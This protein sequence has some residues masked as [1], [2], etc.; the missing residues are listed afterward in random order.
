MESKNKLTLFGA[1]RQKRYSENNQEKIKLNTLKRSL[2]TYSNTVNVP[3]YGETPKEKNRWRKQKQRQ[4]HS[5]QHKFPL[6][7]EINL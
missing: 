7:T 2:K 4:K 3:E 5:L 6:S 1:E